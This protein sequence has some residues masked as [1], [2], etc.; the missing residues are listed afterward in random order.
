MSAMQ[1]FI[2]ALKN[3]GSFFITNGIGNLIQKL[4]VYFISITNTGIGYL[5]INAVP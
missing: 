2:L 1:A 5:V 4:G 3:A